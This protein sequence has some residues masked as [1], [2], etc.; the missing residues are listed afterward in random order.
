MGNR[1]TIWFD[2]FLGEKMLNARIQALFEKYDEDTQSI[3]REVLQVEQAQISRERPR[4]KDDINAIIS[5]V[6][7]K[8]SQ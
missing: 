8:K 4:V 7:E 1:Q 2:G 3:I 6:A 5:R